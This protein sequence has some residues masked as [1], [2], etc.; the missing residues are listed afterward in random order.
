MALPESTRLV[1]LDIEG[2]T[3]PISFVYDT[4]FPYA[5]ERMEA[6]CARGA[7]DPRTAAGISRLR[8][9]YESEPRHRRAELPPFG[10]G[11]PYALD[12][13]RIDRKSTGLKTLQGII[14]EEGYRSGSLRASVFDDVPQALRDWVDGGVRVRIYSSGSVLAQKL[15]FGH[16]DHGDLTPY[17]EA[18][19]DT[20]TGPKKDQGSYRAIAT[21]AELSPA[22]ILF[23]SDSTEELDACR[24]AGMQSGLMIRPG[25]PPCEP[26]S[27]TT[28]DD[29]RGLGPVGP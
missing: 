16:T 4:L 1:L 9:E 27:H 26:G 23:L 29:F 8:E 3:T 24:K 18:Y 6:C 20:T 5:R 28:Y 17:V 11:G 15:L 14:W 2:T 13:M 21:G 22:R 25:N 10:T 12:L 19:H 7:D